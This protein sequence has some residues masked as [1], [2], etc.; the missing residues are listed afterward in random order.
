MLSCQKNQIN[1]PT[2]HKLEQDDYSIVYTHM[3]KQTKSQFFT[4]DRGILQERTIGTWGQVKNHNFSRKYMFLLTSS[5]SNLKK[6]VPV[7]GEN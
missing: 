6:T 4:R 3:N 1:R 7:V 5:I 2:L